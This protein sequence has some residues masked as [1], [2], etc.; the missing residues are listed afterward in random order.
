MRLR[1]TADVKGILL[2]T[3]FEPGASA[4]ERRSKSFASGDLEPAVECDQVH[5]T[6]RQCQHRSDLCGVDA[7]LTSAIRATAFR[8][9]FLPYV[10]DRF[11]QAEG[12][13]S[14]KQGGLGLGLAV[15]R[16]PG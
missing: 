9:S 5:A 8:R 15:V 16:A 2:Q 11:R 1:P 12:S 13:I 6:R 7:R 3:R 14:R 10:F 4:G